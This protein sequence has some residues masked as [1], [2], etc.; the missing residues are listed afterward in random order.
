MTQQ[1]PTKVFNAT[2]AC[3]AAAWMLAASVA[4]AEPV[5]M[6]SVTIQMHELN[7]SGQNGSATITAIG[8]KITV[9]VRI[10]GES[11]SA[12]EP[13]HVHFGRCPNIKAI[14]AYN[15]G[16]VIGGKATS[17]VNLTWAEMMSGRYALNVHESSSMLG[18]YV[19]C[20]NIGDD[21]SPMPLPTEESGY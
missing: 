2:L 16:P 8:N 9:S 10:T 7:G 1:L 5:S 6:A 21:V 4:S 15:V 11:P 14:P 20:G 18:K 17:V 19:S 3:T 13:A 12:S